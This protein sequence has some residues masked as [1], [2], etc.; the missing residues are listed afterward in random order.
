MLD[1]CVISASEGTRSPT[2]ARC[3]RP[4]S[5]STHSRI[6]EPPVLS[7]GTSVK[8]G[9]AG[10]PAG[11][12]VPGA[13]VS[14]ATGGSFAVAACTLLALTGEAGGSLLGGSGKARL[15]RRLIGEG[16]SNGSRCWVNPMTIIGGSLYALKLT[17]S[18]RYIAPVRRPRA[19]TA[20]EE[21][22][23]DM[24]SSREYQLQHSMFCWCIVLT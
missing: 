13:R 23:W 12:S 10:K 24:A 4:V 18:E 11:S 7:V 16:P 19:A 21:G 14:L 6:T 17:I 20:M 9:V 3:V 8:V 1:T 15:V 22:D 2:A 5:S